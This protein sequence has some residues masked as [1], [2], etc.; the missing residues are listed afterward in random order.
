MARRAARRVTSSGELVFA[1]HHLRLAR[2]T[3]QLV[4]GHDH[5]QLYELIGLVQVVLPRG[6][7]DEEAA[8]DRLADV[9]GIEQAADPAG[10]I[11]LASAAAQIAGYG[12][13]KIAS[14][15]AYESRLIALMDA[16]EKA[17]AAVPVRAA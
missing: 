17:A 1:A 4:A 8:H 2:L 11:E 9:H 16:F 7:A 3:G 12:P 5:Q 14:V 6:G 15:K 13:V 10:T